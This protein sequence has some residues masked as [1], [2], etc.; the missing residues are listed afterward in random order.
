[1]ITRASNATKRPGQVVINSG[2][3]RPKEVVQ[4]ER[5]SRAAEKEKIAAAEKE[6][7]DE[8]ARIENDARKKK[9]LGPRADGQRNTITIPRATRVRPRATTPINQ[10]KSSPLKRSKLTF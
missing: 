5:T 2:T 4:A 8:V 1:M 3:H 9:G 6:G 7:I 10:G